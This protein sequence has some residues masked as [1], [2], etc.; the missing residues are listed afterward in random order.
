[1]TATA[2]VLPPGEVLGGYRIREVMGV[3]GMAVVYRAEQLSLNREVAL[4]VLS[5]E[6]GRD[7]NFSERFRREGMHVA[8]LDHPHI[9][10]IYDAGGDKGRLYLAMRLIE[11]PTLGERMRAEP[12]SA[13]ETLNIL[14]PIA[15]GLDAA[16]ATGLVHRD[17]K[18]QNILLTERG[19][20]YLADFGI[21]KRVETTGLTAPGGF[22]GSFHYAAPEQVLGTPTVPAT[23]VYA[24]AAVL[25]LCLTGA[26]PY[27]RDTEAGVLYAHVNEPPPRLPMGTAHEFNAV[28]Q[29]G[30]AKDAANRFASA[31][32]LIAA[33]ERAVEAPPPAYRCRRPAFSSITGG[34]SGEPPTERHR[35]DDGLRET[36]DRDTTHWIEAPRPALE[37]ESIHGTRD[38]DPDTEVTA[39]QAIGGRASSSQPTLRDERRREPPPLEAT[40]ADVQR[41][42]PASGGSDLRQRHRWNRRLVAVVVGIAILV[43]AI[44]VVLPSGGGPAAKTWRVAQSGPLAIAYRS[45]W[46]PTNDAFGAATVAA[47][48][49]TGSSAPIELRSRGA[50]LA[51]GSLVRSATVPGGPPPV[52]LIQFGRPAQTTTHL[53]NGR[54]IPMYSWTPIG[55]RRI[56]TFVIPTVR[57]DL[58]I[59][60]AGSAPNPTALR[61]CEAMATHARVTGVALMPL[62]PDVRLAASLRRVVGT[63]VASRATL[64]SLYRTHQRRPSSTAAAIAQADTRAATMLSKLDV[65]ARYE[66]T[67]S[68]LAVAL[69]SEA[70]AL[71]SLARAADTHNRKMYANASGAVEKASRDVTAAGRRATRAGLLSLSLPA[72][73]VPVMPVVPK[74]RPTSAS[75]GGSSSRPS[76]SAGSTGQTYTAPAQTYSPPPS[77]SSSNSTPPSNSSNSHRGGGNTGGGTTPPPAIH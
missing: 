9:I 15:D 23:D 39:T 68:N 71:T 8:R 42:R 62:G 34:P 51:A 2:V 45:P 20:P 13:E 59:T 75:T 47:S 32:E 26:V 21:A 41:E 77:S 76:S 29:Q 57:G 36:A 22:V 56:E 60:C 49:G 64:V 28:M 43:G 11:G 18:P 63:A 61:S 31:G 66:A 70:S 73:S 52:L 6:L 19:H 48:N 33:A 44:A 35:T 10:P 16:H 5:L 37:D 69:A 14:R 53:A 65:P 50:T 1:M 24:L 67:V 12:L 30:M 3:G 25:Y 74:P 46:V 55:G 40:S 4:K 54:A 27:P 58:A 17:I 72:L 38:A 7:E